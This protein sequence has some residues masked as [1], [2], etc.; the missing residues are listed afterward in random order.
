MWL[1]WSADA[2]QFDGGVRGYWNPFQT[3]GRSRHEDRRAAGQCVAQAGLGIDEL[4]FAFD[5]HPDN[6]FAVIR[7]RPPSLNSKSFEMNP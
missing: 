2:K 3:V 6:H 4:Y 5:D 7:G 1:S